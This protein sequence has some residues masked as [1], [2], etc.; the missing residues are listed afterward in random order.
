M[1]IDSETHQKFW[2]NHAT[3]TISMEQPECLRYHPTRPWELHPQIMCVV[4]LC[5]PL[6]STRLPAPMFSAS[7]GIGLARRAL[8][9]IPNMPHLNSGRPIS[10][11]GAFPAQ[12][13][14]GDSGWLSRQAL[15]D[16]SSERQIPVPPASWHGGTA[17]ADQSSPFCSIDQ[18]CSGSVQ[19]DLV[20]IE[21]DDNEPG[22]H[23]RQNSSPHA[24]ATTPSPAGIKSATGSGG[25]GLLSK[26]PSFFKK[27]SPA[28]PLG[29]STS[30]PPVS[31]TS[32]AFEVISA[33]EEVAL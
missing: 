11:P 6:R 26:L 14:L 10:F 28:T 32:E 27:P 12:S 24:M 22:G 8:R 1:V 31:P 9:S 4:V 5:F 13:P 7:H 15:S 2:V 33:G 30:L 20:V 17:A 21:G 25:G 29:K 19:I 18:T 16:L 23:P 3:K